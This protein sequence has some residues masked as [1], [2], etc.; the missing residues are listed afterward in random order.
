MQKAVDDLLTDSKTTKD[1]IRQEHRIKAR[2][3]LMEDTAKQL[4]ETYEDQDSARRNELESMEG[5]EV[6]DVFY[7]R[8]KDVKEYHRKF[9]DLQPPEEME[10]KSKPKFSGAEWYGSFL[11][12]NTFYERAM[13]MPVFPKYKGYNHFLEIFDK[14]DTIPRRLK[15]LHFPQYNTYLQEMAAYLISFQQKTNPLVEVEDI[16]ELIHSD[17]SKQWKAEKVPGWFG[18][19]ENDKENEQDQENPLY[20][21]SCK[22]L[23]A[24]H[25]TF[26]NHLTGRK[27]IK[28]VNNHGTK[29]VDPRSEELAKTEFLIVSMVD[30]LRDVVTATHEYVIKKQTRTHEEIMADLE[31]AQV[32]DEVSEDES[33]EEEASA[34]YNPLN[35]PLGWDGKPI[36]FWLYKL[37][38]LNIHYK[39]DIC[40]GYTYRGPRAFQRHFNEWR[41]TYGLR[42]LGIENAPHYMHITKFEDA[43]ALNEKIT[44]NGATSGWKPDEEEEFEDDEGNVWNKKTYDDLK[45]QG[46]I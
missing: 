24:K 20:C 14:L 13:N 4:L 16:V 5:E 26:T 33:E 25:S 32:E 37:H 35:L 30:L 17:F 38:G 8:L 23:F 1:R 31:E 10:I 36:P 12:L 44:K 6:F 9:P 28:N 40:G 7:D 46:I 3:Q 34:V 39:C 27:H 43:I 19:D 11:D 41:H 42:C 18:E 21:A 45:R 22:N 15:F 29:K 2:L